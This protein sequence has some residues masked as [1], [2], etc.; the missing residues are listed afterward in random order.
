MKPLK[1]AAVLAGALAAAGAAAPAYAASDAA[2]VVVD[3]VLDTVS[4]QKA[5]DAHL[6]G[7]Q[8]FA[9]EQQ[10]SPVAAVRGVAEQVKKSNLTR[11]LL[12]G[13]PVG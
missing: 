2:P 5:V 12:G 4:K 11:Q 9:P 1:A 7:A 3:G 10:T 13:L 8:Q 6:V